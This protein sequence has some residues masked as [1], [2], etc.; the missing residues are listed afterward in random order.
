M[1]SPAD[2]GSQRATPPGV[3]HHSG[4]SDMSGTGPGTS[5]RIADVGGSSGAGGSMR[6]PPTSAEIDAVIA[7][8]MANAPPAPPPMELAIETSTRSLTPLMTNI[9]PSAIGSDGRVNLFVGNAGTVLRADVS[10]GP[11]NRSRGYGNVLMGSREDAARAIDRFNG[12]TWQ[13]RTLEVRPDRLPPEYEPQPHV[14]KQMY[15]YPP[16]MQHFGGAGWGGGRPPYH[17]PPFGLPPHMN[18]HPVHGA[19]PQGFAR[20]PAMHGH[21]AAV[22]PIGQSPLAGS[23][24]AGQGGA[25]AHGAVGWGGGRDTLAPFGSLGEVA[26]GIPRSTSPGNLG[27]ELAGA[28]GQRS[29][30]PAPKDSSD[31]TPRIMPL[32]RASSAALGAG[33]IGPEEPHRRLSNGLEAP[34][35]SLH[36]GFTPPINMNGLAGQAK[37][38]G[39]VNTLYDRVVFVKNWQDL[40]DLFR[41]AGAVIRADVATAPDGQSRGFGTVLFASKEDAQKAVGMFN[42]HEVDGRVLHVQTERKTLEDKQIQPIHPVDPFPM[43]GT[44]PSPPVWG[45]PSLP[46]EHGLNTGSSPA[47][48]VTPQRS[49]SDEQKAKHPG[50]ISLPPFPNLS[51]M[52]PLSPLQTRG[53][54]PM[55]PSMPGFV[56][57]AY[58][59]TP[60]AHPQFLSPGAGPFSPGLPVTSPIYHQQPFLNAAPGAPVV[61]SG[62]AALST[63]TT[64]AFPNNQPH[65]AAGPPGA[66]MSQDYFPRL[67]PDQS[68]E[69]VLGSTAAL[70]IDGDTPTKR[71]TKKAAGSGSAVGSKLAPGSGGANGRSSLDEARAPNAWNMDRRASWSEVAAGTK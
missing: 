4:N 53:L 47:A 63:P 23:L 41:P 39:S 30:S 10:L 16:P 31:T 20:G 6:Q 14:Q 45:D 60:P 12:F 24:T 35:P 44:K 18:S 25:G 3:P 46:T 38:L 51:E 50:P 5:N 11:D 22:P 48:P 2:V 55:T 71:G 15:R 36:T 68:I 54:P 49:S 58:P 67:D 42:G 61:P 7:A 64:Q 17:G 33:K 37:D 13:T 34:N 26:A 56:F 40:K 8:A 70:K 21:G 62:S 52:N 66:E 19:G 59:S 43:F 27:F 1:G 29:A 9:L 32:G 69:E 57:N 65:S 28:G